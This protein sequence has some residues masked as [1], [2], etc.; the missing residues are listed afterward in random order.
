MKE[1]KKRYGAIKLSDKGYLTRAKN[2]VSTLFEWGGWIF[3]EGDNYDRSP[4]VSYFIFDPSDV[5]D[6]KAE[7]YLIGETDMFDLVKMY[8][9]YNPQVRDELIEQKLTD[10]GV[11]TLG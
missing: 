5:P 1:Q 9:C 6:C 4:V 3:A 11:I 7:T 8:Y 10:I 2:G